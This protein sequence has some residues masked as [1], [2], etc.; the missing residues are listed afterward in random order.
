[1]NHDP[2]TTPVEQAT[3]YY[4]DRLGWSVGSHGQQV[5]LV[6]GREVDALD[7]PCPLAR[8][9]VRAVAAV[10]TV[11][12]LA[13]PTE[14]GVRW[15]LLGKAGWHGTGEQRA[16]LAAREVHHLTSG[17]TV[18]LPPTVFGRQR[19]EWVT[20]VSV[21]TDTPL[22]ALSVVVDTTLTI[23]R[24]GGDPVRSREGELGHA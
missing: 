10:L 12:V 11:P 24:T 23:T 3:T 20:P 15:L 21:F 14:R 17:T 8:E 2:H 4:R 7:L 18:D 1:M 16:A 13:T 5:W 6:S 9:V 19:V 22:P